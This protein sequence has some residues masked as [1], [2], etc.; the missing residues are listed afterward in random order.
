MLHR[1]RTAPDPS[2][3]GKA[4]SAL[5]RFVRPDGDIPEHE[6]QREPREAEPEGPCFPEQTKP[7]KPQASAAYS[8]W[9][10]E[11]IQETGL[12]PVPQPLPKVLQRHLS[13]LSGTAQSVL[14]HLC[15]VP[16]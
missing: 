11:L 15:E 10:P 1:P 14:G 2:C 8:W 13:G 16:K 4:H 12:S 5:G 9:L 3:Q 6:S 7:E